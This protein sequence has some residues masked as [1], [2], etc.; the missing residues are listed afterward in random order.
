PK[1]IIFDVAH[2]LDGFIELKKALKLFFPNK[3]VRVV[4][5]FSKQK[6]TLSCLKLLKTFS[7]FIHV[8]EAKSFKSLPKEEIKK[9]LLKI[10]FKKYKIEKNISV[11]ILDA[12]NLAI[13]NKEI[14]LI[15]GSFYILDE[16]K[17]QLKIK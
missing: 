4:F 15:C 14:L 17:K 16:I 11:A 5:G 2:N 1:A 10:N 9:A 7:S 8:T 13:K 12:K 3:K 6:D